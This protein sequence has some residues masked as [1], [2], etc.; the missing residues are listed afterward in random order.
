VRLS[1]PE[2]VPLK[3]GIRGEIMYLDR[4]G[5]AVT[6]IPTPD[7]DDPRRRPQSVVFTRSPTDFMPIGT[8]YQSVPSGKPLGVFGSAGF[9]EISL[10]GDSAAKRLN[11]TVGEPVALLFAP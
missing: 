9:L 6:N 7:P 4:F 3:N 8:H 1:W 10:N 11:L 2:P 5:N